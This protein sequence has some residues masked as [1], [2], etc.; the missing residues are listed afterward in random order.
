MI[1]LHRDEH[2]TADATI[3]DVEA[4]VRSLDGAERTLI[5]IELPS[6]QTLT[7]GGGP[8]RFVAEV[9]E[10][11]TVRWATID[12]TQGDESIHLVVG[13]QMA[14]YPARVCVTRQVVLDAVRA[15]VEQNGL[16]SPNLTWSGET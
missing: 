8:E 16:R 15:F 3:H 9:A 14:D 2:I 7:V 5:L 6:G 13:G 11:D 1:T 4:A 10:S 12:P